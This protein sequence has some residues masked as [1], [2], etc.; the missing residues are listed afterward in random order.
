MKVLKSWLREYIDFNWNDQEFSDKLSS[1]GTLVDK[2]FT[3][4]DRNI[5]IAQIKKISNHPNA[6]KLKIVEVF[7]GSDKYCI[8]CGASNIMVGQKVPLA[9]I[10][11]KLSDTLIKKAVIREVE[12]CG[13][14]CSEFELGIGD[15]H[16]GIMILED[17]CELGGELSEYINSDTIFDLEITPNRGDCLSHL[18]VAR[19]I[20]AILHKS[21]KKSPIKL[22]M[23][24]EPASS[25][26]KL[27]V[28]EKKLCP[29]YFTRIVKNVSVG[30]SPEW[31]KSRLEICGIKSINNIV[32][33]TNYI[34]LDLG[35]P[36]HAFDLDRIDKH[37]III[38][39]AKKSEKIVT[40]DHDTKILTGDELVIADSKK[41]IAIAG[42]MGG[43]YSEI[44]NHT[45]NIVIEAAEFE[46]KS[47]R[48]TSKKYSITEASYRFERGID[49][50]LIEYSLNKAAKMIQDIAGGTILSGIV[51]Y[52]SNYKKHELIFNYK[53][54]NNLLGTTLNDQQIN[55]ILI[56]LGFKISNNICLIPS[57]RSDVSIWQDLAEEVVRIYGLNKIKLSP[58]K[59][60]PAP[61]KSSYYYN[62]YLKDILASIGF[63]EIFSYPFMSE[64]DLK[65]S[66]LK[67]NDLLE[68][69][70]PT[71]PE[72]KFLRN[73]LIP[74]LLKS[75]SKNPTFDPIMMFEIGNIFSKK[76][77]STYLG[78]ATSGKMAF[79]LINKA[80]DLLLNTL[81]LNI[82]Q[83]KIRELKREELRKLKIKKPS[84]YAFELDLTSLNDSIHVPE[85]KLGL[86]TTT[87][88]VRYRPVSKYPSYTRDLAFVLNKKIK[89][90]DVSKTIYDTSDLVNRVEL[91]DEFSSN[92]LGKNK[93]NLAFH[94]NLQSSSKTLED[95]EAKQIVLK[96]INSIIKKY[97]AKLRA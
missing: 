54:I 11:A 55:S 52:K 49:P 75:I 93:K 20:G 18:G 29:N 97:N 34:M 8:I 26:L 23:I 32:D 24:N 7:D 30:P 73:S 61:K 14:L 10:G 86:N 58:I 17:N 9:K 40:I 53:K 42:V 45:K 89:S 95:K 27:E 79:E 43:A 91:F 94:V 69:I 72:N 3:K 78:V 60:T 64:S 44:S 22:K 90:N 6:D 85:K 88:K 68:V 96:I 37:K 65:N 46:R 87:D 15:D 76:K 47:I 33:I 41:P 56:S 67:A 31:L 80:K 35:Q 50:V 83:D 28:N 84:V 5:V 25:A 4:I 16:D 82:N 36:M 66:K 12:S 57:Y 51:G 74:G 2:F 71:Q 39:K 38:R 48:N 77:E 92:K 81:N 62:E 1:S 63:N 59:K 70:N 19:E 21:V 13:M